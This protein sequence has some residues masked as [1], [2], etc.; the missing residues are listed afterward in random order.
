MGAHVYRYAGTG[1]AHQYFYEKCVSPIPKSL[2]LNHACSAK[3][4]VNP[5]HLE[6]VSRREKSLN[7]GRFAR[8]ITTNAVAGQATY[9]KVDRRYVTRQ[10]C[11]HFTGY[12][13][14]GR[15]LVHRVIYE[16]CKERIP[17][18]M[19]LEHL[20]GVRSCV[21]LQHLE[22]VIR[23]ENVL[24]GKQGK[25]TLETVRQIRADGVSI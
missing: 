1:L 13:R 25:L 7:A 18:G 11:V 4:C 12:G 2:I 9:T 3:T 24:R 5:D 19:D 14:L 16:H 6:P 8:T 22:T 17:D 15:G 10:G 21:D 23:A 20:C